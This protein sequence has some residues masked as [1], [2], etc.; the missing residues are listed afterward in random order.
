MQ[1][2]VFLN[3]L[4]LTTMLALIRIAKMDADFYAYVYT[5]VYTYL[6]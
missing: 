4:Y 2:K 6:L 3:S 5:Y 1:K